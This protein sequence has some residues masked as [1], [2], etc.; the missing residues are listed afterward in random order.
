MQMVR[1][2]TGAPSRS[3]LPPAGAGAEDDDMVPGGRAARSD[4]R[5]DPGRGGAECACWDW[6]GLF[7]G[8][9]GGVCGDEVGEGGGI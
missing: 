6:I 5:S 1:G 3:T 2:A 7:G 4:G 9:V 8:D